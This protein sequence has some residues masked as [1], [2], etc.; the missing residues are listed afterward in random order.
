MA[1]D[2]LGIS[3][4]AGFKIRMEIF[5]RSRYKIL[6]TQHALWESFPLSAG[7]GLCLELSFNLPDM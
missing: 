2:K 7:E 3:S 4:D 1:D 6:R 5:T